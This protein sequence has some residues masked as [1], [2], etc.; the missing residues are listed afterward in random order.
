MWKDFFYYTKSERRAILLLLVVI[1]VLLGITILNRKDTV[2]Y[3][4]FLLDTCGIDSFL[5]QLVE[6]DAAFS[7]S[8]QRKPYSVPV[9]HAFDPNTADSMTLLQLGLPAFVVRN[10]LRYRQKGGVFRSAAAFSKI[11]GLS[12]DD[13]QR[14]LPY[15]SIPE[16]ES[17]TVQTVLPDSIR[18]IFPEDSFSTLPKLEKGTVVALNTADT[19][20]LKRIPGIG[21]GIAKRIV[22]YRNRLGGFYRI[23]QLQEIEYVTPEMNE[24][25]EIS[26]TDSLVKISVNKASLERLRNHPYMN[27][28]KARAIIELRRKRGK[29]KGLPQLSMLEEFTEEDLQRLAPYLAFD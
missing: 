25:F 26:S 7:S 18:V 21:S 11:Y 13:Y 8:R 2:G 4:T 19:A 28:Y 16:A 1:T 12:S 15:L 5:K 22:A 6:V 9:L 27:F 14:L 23:E 3:N 10:I 20:I 17:K 29:I 24:W